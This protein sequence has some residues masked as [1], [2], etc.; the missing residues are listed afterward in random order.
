MTARLLALP[1]ALC[2]LALGPAI[3]EA[4]SRVAGDFN[5]DGFD[6]LAVGVPGEEVGSYRFLLGP[7]RWMVIVYRFDAESDAAFVMR[8]YDGRSSSAPTGR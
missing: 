1:L 7:W 4:E 6:D 3:A 8:I 5:D 2:G